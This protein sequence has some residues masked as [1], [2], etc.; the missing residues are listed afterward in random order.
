MIEEKSELFSVVAKIFPSLQL[1]T[2]KLF[3]NFND[4][5]AIVLLLVLK[6]FNLCTYND[7]P[8]NLKASDSLHTWLI[9]FKKLLDFKSTVDMTETMNKLKHKASKIIYRFIQHHANPKYDL[10]YSQFF[11]KKYSVPF[12]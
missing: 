11:L 3:Q 5:T 7:L 9:F 2:S 8:P 10:P 6:I 4:Q 1:L 12:L